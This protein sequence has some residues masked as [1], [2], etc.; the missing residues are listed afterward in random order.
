MGHHTL[1]KRNKMQVRASH[2]LVESEQQAAHLRD[3]IAAGADFALLAQ[4][5]SQCASGSN[6]GDLGLFGA[7]QMF[8]P[9]EL[10]AFAIEVDQITEPVQTHLGWHLIKR[11]A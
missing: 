2:I 6:G 11:T 7:G 1:R 3:L 8:I 5:H 9:F 10:A 4:Q